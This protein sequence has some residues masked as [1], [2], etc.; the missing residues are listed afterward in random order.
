[1]LQNCLGIGRIDLRVD[2]LVNTTEISD[3]LYFIAIRFEELEGQ[4]QLR[5]T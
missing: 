2:V 3:H 4:E 5:Q 1:M